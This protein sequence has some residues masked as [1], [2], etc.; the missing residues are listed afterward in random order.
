M[1]ISH[2]I[3]VISWIIMQIRWCFFYSLTQYPSPPNLSQGMNNFCCYMYP[4]Q[5]FSFVQVCRL[6]LMNELESS[7]FSNRCPVLALRRGCIRSGNFYF[8]ISLL[9]VY[10][11]NL[12]V[13]DINLLLYIL[14]KFIKYMPCTIFFL[15]YNLLIISSF[16]GCP[17]QRLFY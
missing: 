16:I 6:Q 3:K 7:T 14:S 13:L 12:C 15:K 10:E 1:L 11:R 8:D 4:L 5:N 17:R 9:Y 2:L